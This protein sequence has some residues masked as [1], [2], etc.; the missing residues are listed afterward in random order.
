MMLNLSQG[1]I[2]I[3]SHILSEKMAINVC[4]L[5]ER[6]ITGPTRAYRQWKIRAK[7]AYNLETWET[8]AA[9]EQIPRIRP[10]KDIHLALF[11][12][13]ENWNQLRIMESE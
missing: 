1:S 2:A 9:P 12:Q 3:H 11:I 5:A 6:F 4:P 7:W 8:P 10:V 13:T